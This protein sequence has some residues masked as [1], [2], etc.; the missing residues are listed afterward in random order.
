MVAASSGSMPDNPL[1]PVKLAVEQLR[2]NLT[3]SPLEKAELYAE[4]SDRRVTE[5][6]NMARKG[7]IALAESVTERLDNNLRV[8]AGLVMAQGQEKALLGSTTVTQTQK[9]T[10]P[11]PTIS[12]EAPD[13]IISTS[14]GTSDAAP[15]DS[16]RGFYQQNALNNSNILREA[17]ETAPEEARQ[18]LLQAIEVSEAGYQQVLDVLAE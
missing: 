13:V 18:V 3:A 8:M 15:D 12:V 4:F 1:Y 9:A 7:N 16:L 17:L 11:V 6:V 2:L 10:S 5:I 14:L